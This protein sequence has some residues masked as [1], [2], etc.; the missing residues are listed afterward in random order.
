MKAL[1]H[2]AGPFR[3]VLIHCRCVA[4]R[5]ALSTLLALDPIATLSINR[6]QTKPLHR[7]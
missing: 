7:R 2:D 3:G 6:K 5:D 4:R 1:R